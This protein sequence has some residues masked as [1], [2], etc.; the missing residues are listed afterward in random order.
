MLECGQSSPTL[1]TSLLTLSPLSRREGKSKLKNK[2][3]DV[4]CDKCYYLQ[5]RIVR[6][7]SNSSGCV[8][9]KNIRDLPSFAFPYKS[10]LLTFP[11]TFTDSG[12]L[13]SWVI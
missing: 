2:R 1:I 13:P 7:I 8:P 11:Y 9:S 4:E 12:K 10:T 5:F 3:S 6:Y